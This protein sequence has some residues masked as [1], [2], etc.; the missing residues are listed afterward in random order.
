MGSSGKAVSYV[1][2]C[3]KQRPPTTLCERL[4]RLGDT[5]AP[6]GWLEGRTTIYESLVMAFGLRLV[7]ELK[8]FGMETVLTAVGVTSHNLRLGR[9]PSHNRPDNEDFVWP[10]SWAFEGITHQGFT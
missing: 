8:F 4:V 2:D 6:I 7:E 10:C 9:R 1:I 5:L 3:G